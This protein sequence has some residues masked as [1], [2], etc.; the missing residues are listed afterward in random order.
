MKGLGRQQ[1][2][3]E[4]HVQES[5]GRNACKAVRFSSLSKEAQG[6]VMN[7]A[8]QRFWKEYGTVIEQLAHE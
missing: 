2:P 3:S 8:A 4:I 1:G 7:N 6:A 5:V